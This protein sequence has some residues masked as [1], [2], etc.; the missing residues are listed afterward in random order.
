VERC[1]VSSVETVPWKSVNIVF[2]NS[3][4]AY[5]L[6]EHI[7]IFL[8]DVKSEGKLSNLNGLL[9]SV[10]KAVQS[11]TVITRFRSLGV[12]NKFISKPL[13]NLGGQVNTHSNSI[14]QRHAQGVCYV[15]EQI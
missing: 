9:K 14:A 1:Q 3:G 4:I 12:F 8:E 6:R 13:E 15:E 7:P 11:P 10:L 2:H 5:Y